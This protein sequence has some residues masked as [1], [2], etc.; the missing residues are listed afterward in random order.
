MGRVIA[1]VAGGGRPW[2]IR[3]IN[4]ALLAILP[5]AVLTKNVDLLMMIT[6]AL[7]SIA[8]ARTIVGW[9]PHTLAA[10][11]EDE[12]IIKGREGILT[13]PRSVVTSSNILCVERGHRGFRLRVTYGSADYTILLGK[14]VYNRLVNKL[15][16][17]WGW[18]PP[19]C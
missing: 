5:I 8:I 9:V 19:E 15:R 1:G 10:F 14:R 7:A 16:E 13:I 2:F 12:L 4:T 6:V 3:V 17:H 11:T 18:T